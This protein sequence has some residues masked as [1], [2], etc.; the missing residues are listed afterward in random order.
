[1]LN[2]D[3]SPAVATNSKR[4]AEFKTYLRGNSAELVWASLSYGSVLIAETETRIE[5]TI[6]RV[7][8][9]YKFNGGLRRLWS[10]HKSNSSVADNSGITAR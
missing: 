1:M 4:R 10:R 2:A 6:P 7:V 3:P 9:R 8:Y 5:L